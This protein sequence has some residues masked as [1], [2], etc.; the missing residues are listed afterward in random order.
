MCFHLVWRTDLPVH[1][2]LGGDPVEAQG[3]QGDVGDILTGAGGRALFYR[4]LEETQ[5]H[6]GGGKT[7]DVTTF[8]SSS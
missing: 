7:R 5:V 4:G 8:A 2:E 3:H 6:L 1:T